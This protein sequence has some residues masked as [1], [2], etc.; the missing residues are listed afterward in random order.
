MGAEGRLNENTRKRRQN[1]LEDFKNK[2]NLS[3]K[4]LEQFQNPSEDSNQELERLI[5]DYLDKYKVVDPATFKMI[6][7]KAN[8]LEFIRSNLKCALSDLTGLNFG[9]KVAFRGLANATSALHKEIKQ[10]GR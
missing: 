6:R 8:T 7:P 10:A 3:G 2:L 9:D 1:I 5:V 4:T